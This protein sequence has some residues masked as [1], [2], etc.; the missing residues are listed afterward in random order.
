[1]DGLSNEGAKAHTQKNKGSS[2]K[3]IGPKNAYES[4]LDIQFRVLILIWI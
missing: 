3:I 4:I 1:M 2:D